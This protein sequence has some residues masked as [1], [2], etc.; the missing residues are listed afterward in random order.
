MRSVSSRTAANVAWPFRAQGVCIARSGTGCAPP[1]VICWACS[2]VTE[3]LVAQ[4][5]LL[6]EELL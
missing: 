4:I 6:H 2:F 1:S 5:H 3:Q